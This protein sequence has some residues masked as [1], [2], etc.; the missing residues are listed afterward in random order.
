MKAFIIS[1]LVLL[2]VTFGAAVILKGVF[3]TSAD[4]AYRSQTSTRL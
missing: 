2:I 4:E 1:I 3:S